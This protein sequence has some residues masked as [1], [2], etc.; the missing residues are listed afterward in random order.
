[1][2]IFTGLFRSRDKPKNYYHS[3]SYAYWF[4]RSKSGAE[5]NP[6]TAMQQ[7]AVYACIK[8]LAESVAQLPLHLYE[9]TE[10]G[11]EPAVQHP[12][13]KV[14]HDQPNP[15]MTSYTFRE[16]LMT[17]LLIYG[18]A[19]AQIIRNGRGEVLGLYPLAANRVRVEREDSGELV[20]LYRR[21]D[22]AN[23]NFREQGEI[24]LYDFDVLHIPGMGFDG[25]VGYSPIALSRNAI[26][27]ALDCDQYGS[28][29]FANGA[30]PSGVLKHPG[31]LKDPQKVRDAWEKAYGG[32]GNSHKTAVLEEGMD[33]QPISMTPQD[34]QFLETRKFQIEE[35]A[36][37][38]RL[39]LHMIGDLDHA[40]FSNIE[41]QSLEFVQFTL[42]PW[43][44]RWEQEIQRSLLL[45][46]E[47]RRYFAKFN[48]DGMLRGDYNSRM[49]GY[50]TA[51]Q[52]GW[53]SANDIREREDENRIPAEEGGDLYLVNG[54]F[55][56]LKDA[57][58][59]AKNGGESK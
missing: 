39:P 5:V 19:Y 13:Y 36:R 17:H 43:L 48:V 44:T 22:D 27:L 12:L 6:F 32:A 2:G 55:T 38:Y 1:M 53:M 25:L 16:V 23:P 35:I 29:F 28:S 10:H 20:Y 34:S 59:F 46:Q 47:E 41:Q 7:S 24:R 45:P 50:A 56:K 18:N 4:G 42:M 31:V 58:A 14:L 3:P 9:R 40:T 15:E 37:L 49:Q 51:R 8:V 54:S 26:G 57:G 11:K 21:Y 52:N 30:A 33:Y